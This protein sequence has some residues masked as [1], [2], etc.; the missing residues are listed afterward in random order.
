M[1]DATIPQTSLKK[2][3]FGVPGI[4]FFVL[5]AQTSL[6]SIVG[7]AGLVIALGNGAGAPGAY[8]VVEVV[9]IVF[10]IGFTTITRHLDTRG[11][12]F[13]VISARLGFRVGVGG[14]FL[15]L[16]ACSASGSA[17]SP[18]FCRARR[19]SR[20]SSRSTT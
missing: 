11:G 10:A 3:A 18:T 16:L 7:A 9:V 4:L 20:E 2:N 12:F 17:P 19:C 1:S 8:L 13:A 5:S 6:T 15:A 14:S